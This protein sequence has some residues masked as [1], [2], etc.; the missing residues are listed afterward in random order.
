VDV[1]TSEWTQTA[2]IEHA[3]DDD[4]MEKTRENEFANR[5]AKFNL[6]PSTRDVRYGAAVEAMNRC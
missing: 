3:E 5:E 6:T 2:L 1:G 4:K